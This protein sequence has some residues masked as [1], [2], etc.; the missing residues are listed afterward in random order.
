MLSLGDRDFVEKLNG[1]KIKGAL[2]INR[3][4]E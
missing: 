2:K 3:R 4:I 1:M